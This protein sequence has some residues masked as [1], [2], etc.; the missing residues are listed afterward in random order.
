MLAEVPED[1]R[2]EAIEYL[3]AV[4]NGLKK[5]QGAIDLKWVQACKHSVLCPP[6]LCIPL[7]HAMSVLELWACKTR[8]T[9]MQRRR[10]MT[11]A[12]AWS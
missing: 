2:T 4:Q 12:L 7:L 9:H 5:V 11:F 6:G 3:K 1:K 10:L 8:A